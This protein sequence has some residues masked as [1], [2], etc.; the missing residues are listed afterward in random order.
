MS[1][2]TRALGARSVAASAALL[3]LAAGLAGCGS[4][5]TSAPAGTTGATAAKS[6]AVATGPVTLVN[7]WVRSKD[8]MAT[9]AT[10]MAGDMSMTGVFGMLTNT[11]DKEITVTGGSSPVAGMVEVHET[12]K[13]AAGVMVMQPKAGGFVIPAKGTFELKPGGNH[14]MLMKMSGM[15]KIGTSVQLTLTTSAGP[16]TLTIPVRNFAGGDENYVPAGGATTS[17]SGMTHS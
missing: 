11:T 6:P 8:A 13:N 9:T 1:R 3:V 2:S 16:A 4:S 5:S 17:M 15:P 10:G 7:G 14:I 12:V